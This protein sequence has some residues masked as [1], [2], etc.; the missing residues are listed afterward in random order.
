MKRLSSSYFHLEELTKGVYAAVVR[1]GVGGFSNAGF[2]NLGDHTLVF[3][4]FLTPVAAADLKKAAEL[5][6]GKPVTSVVNSHWHD[7]HTL[8]NQ[9]FTDATMIS[10]KV[11]R[12]YMKKNLFADKE[13]FQ[14]DLSQYLDSI[15]T[16]IS[17]TLDKQMIQGLKHEL[18][19]RKV[20]FNTLS[21]FE[22]VLPSVT[23]DTK[24]EIHGSE[25][26]VELLSFDGG[27]TASDT[28]LY[29]PDDGI[30]FMGDLLFVHSHPLLTSGNPLKWIQILKQ[31]ERMNVNQFVPGHGPIS[32]KKELHPLRHYMEHLIDRVKQL[33]AR[34]I[35]SQ[36]ANSIP[37]P[38]EYYHWKTPQF[39]NKNLAHFLETHRFWSTG[40][41]MA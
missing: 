15:E 30:V 31:I 22:L 17:T 37:I 21:N 3:D 23:F 27:H 2:V 8:G 13:F 14:K 19:D 6:T 10:T 32:S 20:L 16:R 33:F 38:K 29:L 34:G 40:A 36:D 39:Y 11:T 28:I 24:L 4:T 26:S 5:L 9:V 35:T 1:D 18:Q 7:D 25:R 12:D 41:S